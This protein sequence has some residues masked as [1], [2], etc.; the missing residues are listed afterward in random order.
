MGRNQ[1]PKGAYTLDKRLVPRVK[2]VSIKANGVHVY[3]KALYFMKNTLCVCY[4]QDFCTAP[5]MNYML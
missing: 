3:F 5:Y 1:L 4:G 2:E